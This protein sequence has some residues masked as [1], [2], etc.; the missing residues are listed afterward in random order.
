MTI[1]ISSSETIQLV[2]GSAITVDVHVSY[3]E[4]TISTSS[5]TP[6]RQNTAI[7]TAT[8]TTILSAPDSGKIRK[9]KQIRIRNKH[10][11]LDGEITVN[12][13]SSAT[14]YIIYKENIGP[15]KTLLIDEDNICTLLSSGGEYLPSYYNIVAGAYGDGNPSTLLSM[16]Q[17]NGTV[18]A[19][20]TNI[21]TSIARCC[22]F[23]L[24]YDL[25]VNKIRFYGVGATTTIYRTAIYEYSIATRLTSELA[26]TTVANTWG[27]VG[28]NIDLQLSAD[29]LY[30]IA[31]SVNTTGTTAGLLCMGP[32]IAATTGQIQT[33]P[34]S[35]PGNLDTDN[36]YIYSYNFQFAVTT[37]ALPETAPTLAAPAAWTGGM[38]A[39][40]LD[41]DNS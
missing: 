14:S 25:L 30:F 40:W 10:V 34:Q 29:T 13:V 31:C 15:G 22:L 26:F 6:M 20:P 39:F 23:K 16:C 19:T 37:G 2:T 21:T 36:G 32:T 28:N 38:P 5:L 7:T 11:K 1:F 12:V 3:V 18:A 33:A 17:N 4:M 35:L 41:S 9:I 24:P 27:S 8:T